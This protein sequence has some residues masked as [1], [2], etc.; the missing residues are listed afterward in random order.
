MA[1]PWV[2]LV[3]SIDDE[4]VLAASCMAQACDFMVMGFKFMLVLSE[5][6][7]RAKLLSGWQAS[8]IDLIL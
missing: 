6:F 4:L 3:E 7:D 1:H 5:V 8:W 2:V